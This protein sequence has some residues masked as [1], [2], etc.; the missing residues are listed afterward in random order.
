MSN[1]HMGIVKNHVFF[2]R[3]HLLDWFGIAL[4]ELAPRKM[5]PFEHLIEIRNSQLRFP[6]RSAP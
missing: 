1:K 6:R 2:V 4:Y 3:K 5:L